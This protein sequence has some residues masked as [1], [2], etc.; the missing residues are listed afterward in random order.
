MSDPTPVPAPDTGTP[1]ADENAG[2]PSAIENPPEAAPE[3]AEV[4]EAAPAVEARPVSAAVADR[5]PAIPPIAVDERAY[6]QY[7]QLADAVLDS[8]EIA[9]RAAETAVMYARELQQAANELRSLS[10]ANEKKAKLML[11]VTGA[12]MFICLVF[13]LVMGV[14]L[15]GRIGQLDATVLAVGKRVV[16]LN[17]GLESIGAVNESVQ[18]LASKQNA[19]TE[20]QSQMGTQIEASL[21]QSEALVEKLP[22]E[23]AKKMAASTEDMA[24]TLHG[25][26]GRLQAQANAVQSLGGEVKALKG[27]VANV[28]SLKRDVEALVTLQKERYLETLQKQRSSAAAAARE[29][30]AP[31]NLAY[32]RYQQP[33]NEASPGA[34][35]N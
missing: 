34:A 23:A 22:A 4:A 8:A 30:P 10:A 2:S 15:A 1:P 7:Q 25:I 6:Q 19:L 32:P 20:A 12:V 35:Q 3:V 18:H 27:S 9:S 24:K 33:K 31:K 5:A 28:D 13:F 11:S 17:A 29:Q 14:R 21:K 26:N 16:E